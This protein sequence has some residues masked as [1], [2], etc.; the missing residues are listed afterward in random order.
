MFNRYT[1]HLKP[2]SGFRHDNERRARRNRYIK[3]VAISTLALI[4]FR[5]P[6]AHVASAGL[7]VIARPLLVLQNSVLDKTYSTTAY[8][9]S[10][11][12]LAAENRR[13]ND[14]LASISLHAYKVDV[15]ETENIAL[16]EELGRHPAHDALL[17]RVLATPGQSP[18]DTLIIDVGKDEGA[19]LGAR[20]SAD[21]DIA[22]GE[23]ST[24]YGKSALVTLYSSSGYELPVTVGTTSIPATAYGVGG[25]NFR[26]VLPRGL[27]VSM[28]DM[29]EIPALTPE[30]AGVVRAIQKP[31]GGSL[32]EIFFQW[33]MNI[34]TL[35]FV[36]V[37][38]AGTSTRL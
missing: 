36:Y 30:F 23:I 22:L 6:V 4:I 10:K 3:I 38:T 35:R 7:A 26:I 15:L 1:S 24:L 13:L 34:E 17:A 32:Q 5:T 12:V 18:F 28:G 16:K 29:I 31:T 37:R 21:G 14:V 2:I 25:G 27:P 19:T 20:V 8:F 9:E 11:S 33:P